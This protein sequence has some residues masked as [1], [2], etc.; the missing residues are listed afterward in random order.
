MLISE[1]QR[2]CPDLVIMK[3]EDLTLFRDM[4]KKLYNF[5]RGCSWNKR[6]ERLGLDE[7]F[8]DVTDI[9][10]YNMQFV[11]PHCL[12]QSFFHLSRQDPEKGFEF[13]ASVIAGC[14][15]PPPPHAA[16]ST[17]P[18]T[19]M[20]SQ[21]TD[22][23]QLSH[24]AMQL[25]VASHL[26][27]HLRHRIETDFRL[28]ASCGVSTNKLLSKL[29]GNQNKP[30]GQTTLLAPTQD[31]IQDFMDR[32][33]LRKVP[34]IGFK[35][36][37]LLESYIR[38][39]RKDESVLELEEEQTNLKV[40]DVRKFPGMSLQE[41]ADVLGGPGTEKGVGEKVWSLLH[42]NDPTEVK[43]AVDVPTQISIEDTY[44]GIN[45]LPEV[46]EQIHILAHSLLKRMHVDLVAVEEEEEYGDAVSRKRWI[47]HPKTLRLTTN[48]HRT[49]F[50]SPSSSRNNANP[51]GETQRPH[52]AGRTSRSQPLPSFV[53]GLD[54]HHRDGSSSSSE[55]I[56]ERLVREYLVPMFRQ[57][58]PAKSGWGITLI[59]VCVAGIVLSGNEGGKG[60]GRDIG[61]MFRMQDEVLKGWRVEDE[62]GEETVGGKANVEG[63]G[64]EWNGGEGWID[65]DDDD[66]DDSSGGGGYC[67]AEKYDFFGRVGNTG[68]VGAVGGDWMTGC[69]LCGHVMPRFAMEAHRRYHELG[70]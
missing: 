11:N 48:A 68:D 1:A 13:D 58:N 30:N 23:A 70:N 6:V 37:S 45:T 47:A 65:D 49:P 64:E 19:L 20:S 24:F 52:W 7:V 3:G 66:D 16:S 12:K 35:T 31:L 22:F 29:V 46:I 63:D 51:G 43:D 14:V 44:K 34:G 54:H 4:S 61:R 26:A 36:S 21:R 50:S 62:K 60:E 55:R 39:A 56:V 67:C 2:L 28:T 33:A 27:S 10:E 32:H 57:L 41:L 15:H 25:T 42:G 5:L 69:V 17:N 53:L 18:Q 40:R 38:R 59:N 9:V 8:L